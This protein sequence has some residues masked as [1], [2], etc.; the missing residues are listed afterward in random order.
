MVPADGIYIEIHQIEK[1][2]VSKRFGKDDLAFNANIIS[3]RNPDTIN[4][5]EEGER[6]RNERKGREKITFVAHGH[7][8]MRVRLQ[9]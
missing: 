6:R 2:W 3:A 5:V 9:H 4:H 7:V 8:R 1:R